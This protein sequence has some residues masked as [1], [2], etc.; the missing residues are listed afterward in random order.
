MM[1]I[2]DGQREKFQL[3]LSPIRDWNIRVNQIGLT[4]GVLLFQLILSPIRDWN[5]DYSGFQAI[6]N[7]SN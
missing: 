2:G 6:V 3:I 4:H 1:Q 5:R 7:C